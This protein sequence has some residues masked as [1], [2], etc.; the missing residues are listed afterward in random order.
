V[1]DVLIRARHGGLIVLAKWRWGFGFEWIPRRLLVHVET[2]STPAV[3]VTVPGEPVRHLHH[4]RFITRAQLRDHRA[5]EAT[6]IHDPAI[7]SDESQQK[8]LALVTRRRL[9]RGSP[10]KDEQLEKRKQERRQRWQEQT[11]RLSGEGD[12][13]LPFIEGLA[14]QL[15][16]EHALAP[17]DA[18]IAAFEEAFPDD[19]YNADL[20]GCLHP[21]VRPSRGQ[22]HDKRTERG[23]IVLHE[24]LTCMKN[25]RV[26]RPDMGR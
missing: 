5:A 20:Y 17:K 1:S 9:R 23:C 6:T 26:T 7:I 16:R 13:R 24:W 11:R 18:A 3:P 19:H 22:H 21:Q 25:Q 8:T 12:W 15:R 2:I 4:M 10:Q 14:A